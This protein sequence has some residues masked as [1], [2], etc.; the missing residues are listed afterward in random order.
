MPFFVRGFARKRTEDYARGLADEGEGHDS[1]DILV[2]EEILLAAKEK[3][4]SRGE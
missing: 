2:T 3:Q 1:G 4:S